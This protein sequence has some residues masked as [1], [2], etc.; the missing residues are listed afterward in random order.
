MRQAAYIYDD[1]LSRHVLRED[2]VMRPSRLR[3]TYELL[4]AYGAFRLPHSRLVSPRLASE[5]EVLT[6]H[7]PDYV[8]AV[9]SFSRGE[10]PVNP[11]TYNFSNWGDN[12]IFPGMWEASLLSVGASL[13]AADLVARG[14]VGVAFNA[15]GGLHHAAAGYASGFCVFNDPVIAI[16]HL[17]AQGLKVAYV[18]IDAHHGDGVQE[19]F[20]DSDA[21]L[22][23]SLHESGRYLFPGTGE[24]SEMGTGPGRGYAV[25]LPL[26]PYTDDDTYLW[27]FQEVVPPLIERF[28]PDILVSQLGVDTHYLDPITHM[29]LTT[30]GYT[31]VV[32]AVSR[33]C[34]RWLALGGGGYDM[35]AV[36][37]CWTLAYGVMAGQEWPDEVPPA[38]RESYGLAYL[39]DREGPQLTEAARHQAR[40]F[41]EVTVA[42]LHRQV[43]PLH[44]L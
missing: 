32:E 20:Y 38:Y 4:E 27:A 33:L 24:V 43:F 6:F 29:S 44:G 35:G 15:S 40:R 26:A 8:A 3:Y 9:R 36:A 14:E 37:R 10:T 19:A 11:M 7:N 5:E 18:D 12:P 28:H 22:T 31:R 16:K 2:H 41:A 23:I 34:P 25:N 39:R 1:S 30:S 42:S 13:V 21:V 17:L